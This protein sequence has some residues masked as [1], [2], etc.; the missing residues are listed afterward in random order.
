MPELPDVELLRRYVE[1]TSLH[2]IIEEAT[3]DAPRMLQGTTGAQARSRLVNKAFEAARR[4]GKRL[5]TS[6]NR[7]ISGH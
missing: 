1:A 7:L 5:E 4:H 3:I 6:E 2:K